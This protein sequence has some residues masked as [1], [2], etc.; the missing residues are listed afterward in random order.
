MCACTHKVSLV[1]C[2]RA[3]RLNL[4]RGFPT[5]WLVRVALMSLT[6]IY[7]EHLLPLG[8]LKL[9]YELN[10]RCLHIYS[11]IKTSGAEAMIWPGAHTARQTCHSLPWERKHALRLSVSKGFESY[12]WHSEDFCPATHFLSSP[13]LSW[14]FLLC[15]TDRK[16]Q[17]IKMWSPVPTNLT[18]TQLLDLLLRIT[19]EEET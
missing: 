5:C 7:A 4:G 13:F 16:L 11:P 19:E 9:S 12:P 3:W 15:A 8:S 18:T 6:V 10:G 1:W 17:P 14:F 2:A